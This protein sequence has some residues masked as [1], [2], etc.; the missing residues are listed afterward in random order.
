MYSIT[1][2][3]TEATGVI[4]IIIFDNNGDEIATSTTVQTE[5]RVAVENMVKT[6]KEPI[7]VL[8]DDE[9]IGPEYCSVTEALET[10]FLDQYG[11]QPSEAELQAHPDPNDPYWDPDGC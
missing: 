3:P 6:I 5:F 4:E 10:W 9:V 7:G 11:Y 8:M 1:A 2:R